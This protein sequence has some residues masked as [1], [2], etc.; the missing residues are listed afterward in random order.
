MRRARSIALA[1]AA[2]ASAPQTAH[3]DN[4]YEAQF[5]SRSPD[6]TLEA[7]EV[8][9]SWFR[10]RNI[11]T[12]VWQTNIFVAPA[13]RMGT[14]NPRGRLSPFASDF[15]DH[16]SRPA[17]IDNPPVNPGQDGTFTFRVRAPAVDVVST[18]VEHFEPLA[19]LNDII[20]DPGGWTGYGTGAANDP[21]W[22]TNGIPITY[23]VIPG[24]PPA[25][26]FDA[27]TASAQVGAAID[28]T[29][30]GTDNVR[31]NRLEFRLAGR[32]PVL[33]NAPGDQARLS[34]TARLE[35]AGL[36]AGPHPIEVT[37]VDGSGRTAKAAGQV[38][39]TAPPP[40]A[41]GAN[42]TRNATLAAGFGRR[43]LRPRTT[44]SY[45]GTTTLRGRLTGEGGAPIAG[46]AVRIATRVTGGRRGF[47][48]LSRPLTTSAQGAFTY[49]VP[50][51]ASRQIQLS[52]T[53]FSDDAAPAATR[54]VRFSTR[55]GVRLSVSPGSVRVGRRVRLSGL[56]RGG[57]R[58]GGGVLVTLEGRQAGFGWRSFATV[59]SGRGGRFATSY[60]FRSIRRRSTVRFRA[61]VRQQA[62]YPY[63]T[64]RSAERRVRV[65]P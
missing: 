11:G 23:R 59:R 52:Y 54:T 27:A 58:P 17:F 16:P 35:T 9:T 26:Q 56:L 32:P 15:W 21:R 30:T 57:H 62:G 10:A 65:R 51:G 19:E 33:V 48:Q 2:L 40:V 36:A 5:L 46:A 43:R 1:A 25:A 63:A 14:S 49:R 50:P 13:F 8:G 20:G 34:T 64:G 4:G 41:N 44:V 53:A 39:L 29:A 12:K 3:A 7:G 55:A 22:P 37:A 38:T 60:R 31:V 61:V 6:V 24:R 47:R 18:F 45:G 28:V 42:A